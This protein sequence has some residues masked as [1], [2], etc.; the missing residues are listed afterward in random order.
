MY[1]ACH[2][3]SVTGYLDQINE[4]INSSNALN[5]NETSYALFMYLLGKVL[6]KMNNAEESQIKKILGNIE[7]YFYNFVISL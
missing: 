6:R 2:S 5:P 7:T 1:H 4:K 3:G